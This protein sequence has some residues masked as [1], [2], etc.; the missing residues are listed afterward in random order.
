M[1]KLMMVGSDAAGQTGAL[2]D[3]S[4]L[5]ALTEIER[6]VLEYI[7]RAALQERQV[8]AKDEI[9]FQLGF[10]G[11]GTV[12]GIELRLERKGYIKIKCFQR[13]RQM[14]A[15]RLGKWTKPPMCMVPH[16]TTIRDHSRDTPSLPVGTLMQVPTVMAELNAIQ[17][18]FNVDFAGA[19]L[20]LNSHGVQMRAFDR[21]RQSGSNG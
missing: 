10:K 4:N 20:I 2:A 1:R 17:R 5:P 18:E 6:K 7:E 16:W 11:T 12:R 21:A 13:G 15:V 14:Y 19:Q 9:A 8:E 3:T